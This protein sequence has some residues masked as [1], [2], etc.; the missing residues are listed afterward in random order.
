MQGCFPRGDKAAKKFFDAVFRLSAKFMT[1]S[2]EW[3]NLETGDLVKKVT[4]TVD[5]CG[6]DG[7]RLGRKDPDFYAYVIFSREFGT[8][9]GAKAIP[10]K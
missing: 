3:Y 10:K 9:C 5:W 7:I 4:G 8:W 1:N 6:P 2:F